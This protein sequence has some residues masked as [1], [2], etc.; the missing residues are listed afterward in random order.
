MSTMANRNGRSTTIVIGGGIRSTA[1]ALTMTA[2]AAAASVPCS[3]TS[4]SALCATA[5]IFS[6]SARVM[7]LK[8]ASERLAHAQLLQGR[9]EINLASSRN[10]GMDSATWCVAGLAS[11]PPR[12]PRYLG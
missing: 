9:D 8:S 3:S 6:G 2:V 12:R 11:R 7:P 1:D 4:I 5:L 10:M